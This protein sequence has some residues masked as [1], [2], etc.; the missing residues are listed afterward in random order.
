MA[1]IKQGDIVSLPAPPKMTVERVKYHEDT[2]EKRLLLKWSTAD[3]V[4]HTR[5]FAEGELAPIAE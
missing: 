2:G 4:E 3:G 1:Q 5:W